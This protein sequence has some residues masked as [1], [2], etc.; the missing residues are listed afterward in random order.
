MCILSIAILLSLGGC[1]SGTNVAQQEK[2]LNPKQAL[3]NAEYYTH[4]LANELFAALLPDRQYRYAVAGFVPVDT[5]KQNAKAQSPLMHLGQQLE[6]GLMTEAVKRGFVAQDFKAAN[7][8]IITATDDRVLTRDVDQLTQVQR[9][10]YFITGTITSQASGAM[11][12]ARV[13][14]A[15]NKDVVA[16]ATQFFPD[17]IFWTSERVS[18]RAGRLYR[19]ESLVR[20]VEL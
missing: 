2:T 6:Q 20:E 7:G 3:G 14:D 11:V 8:I 5:F 17:N 16:A 15:R 10:D 4:V 12:N 18:T 1:A 19:N 9:V 13:I